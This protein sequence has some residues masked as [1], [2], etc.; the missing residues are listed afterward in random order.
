MRRQS[1][2]RSGIENLCRAGDVIEIKSTRKNDIAIMEKKITKK[3]CEA[4]HY[5]GVATDIAD[6]EKTTPELVKEDVKNLNNNPR[7]NKD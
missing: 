6:D 2:T 3:E 4:E 7:N 5:P 1:Q